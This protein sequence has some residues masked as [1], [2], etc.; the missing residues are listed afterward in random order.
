[1]KNQ[2]TRNALYDSIKMDDE[3][4][5][6]GVLGMSWGDRNGPPYPLSGSAKKIARAEAKK[7][8]EQEKRLEKM[9]KAAANKRKAE[10][11]AAKKQARVDKKKRRLV[12]KGDMDKIYKNRKLFSTEELNMIADRDIALKRTKQA[13]S[14]AK[15]TKVLNI[16]D[17]AGSI[18]QKALPIVTITKGLY[19]LKKMDLDADVA[20]IARR[21]S[22]KKQRIALISAFNPKAAVAE[23]NRMYGTSYTFNEQLWKQTGKDIMKQLMSGGGGGKQ[24]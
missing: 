24:K 20:E 17:Q 7:K 9:R 19:D 4:Y 3:L 2:L 14:A 22:T 18:A 10:A 5:H 15:L 8:I 1:M 12:A 11:R 23:M 13:E 6:H 21:E 16:M